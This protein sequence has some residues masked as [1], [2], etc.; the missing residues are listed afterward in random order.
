MQDAPRTDSHRS[1]VKGVYNL[2]TSLQCRFCFVSSATGGEVY[3]SAT[4]LPDHGCACRQVGVL[5][6]QELL[7]S[8]F[9][10]K[11]NTGFNFSLLFVLLENMHNV[12]ARR[13]QV[14]RTIVSPAS[15]RYGLRVVTHCRLPADESE[16]YLRIIRAFGKTGP[17]DEQRHPITQ[18]P[19]R[20]GRYICVLGVQ[21]CH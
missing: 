18:L 14:R 9:S 1:A 16:L 19:C 17:G 21:P 12:R 11:L 15:P 6:H 13:P 2:H 3:S 7:V 20:Y 5:G 8:L 4:S 10:M